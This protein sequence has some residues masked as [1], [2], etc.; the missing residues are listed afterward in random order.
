M[1]HIA[2]TRKL[3]LKK[4]Y[5]LMNETERKWYLKDYVANFE[6]AQYLDYA[7]DSLK[8]KQ[9]FFFRQCAYDHP[10]KMNDTKW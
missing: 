6:I 4:F 3:E 2:N 8:N 9:I 10:Q 7:Y 1:K 5:K